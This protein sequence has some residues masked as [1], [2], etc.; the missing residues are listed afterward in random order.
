MA[1][2]ALQEIE[3]SLANKYDFDNFRTEKEIDDEIHRL[4]KE[5]KRVA[6]IYNYR[7]NKLKEM[8]DNTD[9]ETEAPEDPKEEPQPE[10]TVDETENIDIDELEAPEPVEENENDFELAFDMTMYY[11]IYVNKGGEKIW[12]PV[13]FTVLKPGD[14]FRVRKQFNDGGLEIQQY[15]DAKLLTPQTHPYRRDNMDIIR[16]GVIKQK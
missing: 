3:A 9:Y 15:Y 11:D 4:D 13:H 1:K 16:V 12:M 2:E 5:K 8:R 14:I 7:I 10:E 6:R